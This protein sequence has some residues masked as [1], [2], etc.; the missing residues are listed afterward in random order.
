MSNKH[1]HFEYIKNSKQAQTPLYEIYTARFLYNY[2]KSRLSFAREDEF[3]EAAF[4]LLTV[5][6]KKYIITRLCAPHYDQDKLKKWYSDC[7]DN[8]SFHCIFYS[9]HNH[10]NPEKIS[11]AS[12]ICLI[13]KYLARLA[14]KPV[15]GYFPEKKI[16]HLKQLLKLT[17][18]DMQLI[19]FAF[20][21]SYM[22]D[23]DTFTGRW[24]ED[25]KYQLF[26]VIFDQPLKSISNCFTPGS[27]MVQCGLIKDPHG[28]FNSM[29]SPQLMVYLN[30]PETTLKDYLSEKPSAGPVYP[31]AG[32][33]L[34]DK[35]R[36]TLTAMVKNPRPAHI[37]FYGAPGTGKT[38]LSKT[39]I[40]SAGKKPVFLKRDSNQEDNLGSLEMLS[41]V[42]APD[43]VLIVDEA[44]TILN[45]GSF[46]F[47]FGKRSLDKGRLNRFFDNSRR[48]S[49]I[50]I[51]NRSWGMESSLRRRFDYSYHFKPFNEKQ[52]A[53]LWDTILKKSPVRKLLSGEQLKQLVRTYIVDAGTISKAVSRIAAQNP[54]QNPEEARARLCHL[55]QQQHI[56]TH[57]KKPVLEK[58]SGKY[59]ISILNTDK[60][61]RALLNA[62]KDY[63]TTRDHY[64]E[65]LPL[66]V[67]FTGAPGTGKTALA[68]HLARSL[69]KGIMVKKASDF[70]DMFV[71]GTEKNIRAAFEEAADEDQILLVDEA[72]SFLYSRGMAQKSWEISHVNEFLTDMEN[73]YG[74]LICSTNFPE[75]L[76]H[77]SLRRFQWK[78]DFKPLR[79]KDKMRMF[80]LYFPKLPVPADHAAQQL[81]ALNPLMPGDFKVVYDQ[82]RYYPPNKKTTSAALDLLAAEISYK[83]EGVQIGF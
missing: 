68:R 65:Q 52:R 18:A 79:K 80:K 33:V 21:R 22:P 58:K 81:T 47:I 15:S 14:K 60:C 42:A 63:Y 57:G 34:P 44:D 82:L 72:D 29:F 28:N 1:R 46:D 73:F 16:L 76:D 43:E 41:R 61:P 7:K 9:H 40:K 56:L 26:P 37:L 55:L 11:K 49:I 32:F 6:Q 24:D 59:D 17:P 71:G 48:V 50:W 67:L 66:N 62:L 83:K 13:Y 70:L 51:T 35:V 69:D 54:A 2:L 25:Q 31:L 20:A 23:F 30:T 77:A 19:R 5:S 4:D 36:H 53:R 75:K 38:E 74:V 39:L 8:S 10:F 64:Q 12:L 27:P 45:T 78:I 3:M